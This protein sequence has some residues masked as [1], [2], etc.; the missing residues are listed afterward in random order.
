MNA[1]HIH[2]HD[3]TQVSSASGRLFCWAAGEVIRVN[4]QIARGA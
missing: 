3:K 1:K 4:A 2:Y